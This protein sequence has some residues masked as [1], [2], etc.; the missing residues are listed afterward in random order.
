MKMNHQ[1]LSEILDDITAIAN[2]QGIQFLDNKYATNHHPEVDYHIGVK[3]LINGYKD[4]GKRRLINCASEGVTPPYP[5]YNTTH[6]NAIGQSMALLQT[7]EL[8]T[9]T[10][11]EVAGKLFVFSYLYLSSC[12]NQ[13]GLDA[14]QSYETRASLFLES[15][16]QNIVYNYCQHLGITGEM[17]SML[18]A[19]DTFQSSLGYSSDPIKLEELSDK[20]AKMIMYCNKHVASFD[21]VEELIEGA[22]MLH[23]AVYDKLYGMIR[24]NAT[25]NGRIR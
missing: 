22:K 24:L 1:Q 23:K 19:Y 4:I 10:D 9:T 8:L 21:S 6:S 20:A 3:A 18:T 15:D 12:I 17:I 11:Q 13:I 16:Y 14:Y 25:I 5:W 7:K 2:R